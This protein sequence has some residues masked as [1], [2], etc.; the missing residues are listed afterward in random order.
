MSCDLTALFNNPWV[1]SEYFNLN[2]PLYSLHSVSHEFRPKKINL[3]FPVTTSKKLGSVGGE[4]CLFVFCFVFFNAATAKCNN[5][6]YNFVTS[7]LQQVDNGGTCR[8]VDSLHMK[9]TH[10]FKIIFYC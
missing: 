4:F 1:S 9:N 3:L 8:L 6:F 5:I 2:I 7:D 10:I